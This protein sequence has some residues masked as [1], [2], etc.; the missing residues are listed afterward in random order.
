M[1]PAGSAKKVES[2][3]VSAFVADDFLKNWRRHLFQSG[4]NMDSALFYVT[5]PEATTHPGA[6]TYHERVLKPV[7]PPDQRPPPY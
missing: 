4:G 5:P 3:Q 2:C 6:E 7:G 1:W